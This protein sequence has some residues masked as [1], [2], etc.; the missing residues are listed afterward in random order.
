[1]KRCPK[2]NFENQ[3]SMNFC[4]NCGSPLPN[5]PIIV[6]LGGEKTEE[7]R[8]ET[9][10]FDAK[11]G[12]F[13]TNFRSDQTKPP[14]NRS[15]LLPILGG[16]AALLVLFGMLGVAIG[17]Q[18]IKPIIFA[19]TPTPTV[20]NFPTPSIT[21]TFTRAPSTSPVF[22]PS[23]YPSI[24]PSISPYTTP[25]PNLT[26]LTPR[27]DFSEMWVDYNITE[28]GQ[29]GM[30]IHVS[31]RVYNL[32]GVDSYL[33]I[34]FQRADDTKLLTNNS[35]FRS[36]TGQLALYRS[37]KPNFDD[38]VYNDL[39]LFMPYEEFNLR[40]GKYNLKMDVDLI[41][42]NGGLIQHLNYYDFSYTK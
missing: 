18:I 41:Y 36:S 8:K 27:A 23:V 19:P 24:S 26:S 13:L 3:G 20:Y 14:R 31:C 32:K 39:Q 2:C 34:T 28:N 37:L 17:Y 35:K 12:A 7:F 40:P 21:P 38:A 4:L 16:I 11:K 25:S 33:V 30:R 9:E 10:T 5:S 1:M 15:K 29:L 42:K 22:I 6:N